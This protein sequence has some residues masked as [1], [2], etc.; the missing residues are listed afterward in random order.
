MSLLPNLDRDA[1]GFGFGEGAGGVAV[2]GFPGL[3]VDLGLEDGFQGRGDSGVGMGLSPL[4]RCGYAFA[5]DTTR[6]NTFCKSPILTGL[7][8]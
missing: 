8:R 4:A 1:A 5:L 7:L 2:Q 3:G 6:S